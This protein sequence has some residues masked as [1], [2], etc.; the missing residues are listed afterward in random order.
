MRR[1][2]LV[3]HA[4]LSIFVVAFVLKATM[5]GPDTSMCLAMLTAIR[6]LFDWLGEHARL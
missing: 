5:V 6:R 3:L 2:G 1:F 4:S